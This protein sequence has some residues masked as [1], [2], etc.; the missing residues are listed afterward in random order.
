MRRGLALLLAAIALTSCSLAPAIATETQ[1]PASVS[2]FSLLKFHL[3]YC[4]VETSIRYVH[5]T[6]KRND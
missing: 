5:G 2:P 4:F 1:A 3:L 6:G